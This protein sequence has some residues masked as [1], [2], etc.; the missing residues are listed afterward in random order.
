MKWVLLAVGL[1]LLSMRQLLRFHLGRHRRMKPIWTWDWPVW[2]TL[3]KAPY[4]L[5]KRYLWACR[6]WW[7]MRFLIPAP[8]VAEY[9]QLGNDRHSPPIEPIRDG[10]WFVFAENGRPYRVNRV[11]R[12]RWFCWAAH[13]RD[14]EG[15]MRGPHHLHEYRTLRSYELMDGTWVPYTPPEITAF[16]ASIQKRQG[17]S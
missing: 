9:A 1:Y 16:V 8:R 5:P 17:V 4:L 2:K 6:S 14:V 10:D 13:V 7:H 15:S 3:L 12:P 11:W